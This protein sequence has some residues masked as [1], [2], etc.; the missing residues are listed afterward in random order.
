MKTQAELMMTMADISGTLYERM[1]SKEIERAAEAVLVG[2][3]VVKINR[4]LQGKGGNEILI[5]KRVML[6]ATVGAEGASAT[7]QTPSYDS[8]AIQMQLLEAAVEI[9]NLSLEAADVDI[10]NDVMD[11]LGVTLSEKE[12]LDIINAILSYTEAGVESVGTG[13]A[14]TT[15]DLSQSGVLKIN[16]VIVDS[17]TLLANGT[18]FT[19]GYLHGHITLS[20]A[21]SA[22]GLVTVDYAYAAS[23]TVLETTGTGVVEASD[24]LRARRTVL[25]AKFKP[26]TMLIS[27]LQE[28]D[29]LQITGVVDASAYGNSR[30]IQNGEVG[31]L[32]GL[33]VYT[34][35]QMP[36][37]VVAVFDSKRAVVYAIKKELWTVV[38]KE[39]NFAQK[40]TTAV[41]SRIWS[42][43]GLVN[44]N[45]VCLIT[46][47][48]A[49]SDLN[50]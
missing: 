46:G 18:N 22:G 39:G 42:K 10:L 44:E 25:D 4:S 2:R 12:D 7:L 32:F 26:D 49:D 45:A 17:V 36:N 38:I 28:Q 3:N 15:F 9:G 23:V 43:A 27:P 29:I 47:A 40:G 19:V 13:T 33:R 50:T 34:T 21:P 37:G 5:P 6:D 35:T 8:V 48:Q 11:N 41:V 31:T 24:I 30:P 20:A 1:L 14:L 16:E